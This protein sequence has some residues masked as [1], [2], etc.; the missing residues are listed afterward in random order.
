MEL[1]THR[2]VFDPDEEF[3]DNHVYCE[4]QYFGPV[5]CREAFH[6]WRDR[7]A[8]QLTNYTQECERVCA[9]LQ[10]L[11]QVYGTLEDHSP[12]SEEERTLHLDLMA[13][14]GAVLNDTRC[15]WPEHRAIVQLLRQRFERSH[16]VFQHVEVAA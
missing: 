6:A 10:L 8:R 5:Q 4:S 16:P 13:L 2:Q 1:A 9:K 11:R 15:P 3:K 14:L 12:A 7:V